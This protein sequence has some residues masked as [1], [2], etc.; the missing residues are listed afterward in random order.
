VDT[1]VFAG[2]VITQNNGSTV[3]EPCIAVAQ[4]IYTF[5]PNKNFFISEAFGELCGD[6]IHFRSKG[7]EPD[8]RQ[9]K[10]PFD[11]MHAQCRRHRC[12]LCPRWDRGGQPH[13]DR[14]RAPFPLR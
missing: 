14:L 3:K 9:R 4:F 10:Y 1:G 11:Y 6:A 5:D 13:L 2:I 7:P 8:F 12:R